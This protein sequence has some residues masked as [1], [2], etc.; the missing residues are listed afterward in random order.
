MFGVVG[1][2]FGRRLLANRVGHKEVALKM[3]ITGFLLTLTYDLA[4]NVV[5]ALTISWPM[6]SFETVMTF[7][8]SGISF[9]VVH[10]I[11]NGI[12]F[13]LRVLPLSSS[14]ERITGRGFRTEVRRRVWNGASSVLG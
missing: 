8:I 3:A 12:L 10:E 7:L 5:F 13:S 9:T 1:G 4:T 6:T 14:I 2:T 11:G